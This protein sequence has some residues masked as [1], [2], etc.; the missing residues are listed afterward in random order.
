MSRTADVE[1]KADGRPQAYEHDH[2]GSDRSSE[3][4]E[5]VGAPSPSIS[6][7]PPRGQTPTPW[8]TRPLWWVVIVLLAIAATAII[9]VWW[10]YARQYES[11][12]D[13]FIAAHIVHIAPQVSGQVKAVLVKDNQDVQAGQVLVKID[14]STYQVALDQAQ[15]ALAQ[16]Q[17]KVAQAQAQQ[18]V[19]QANA[20]QAGAQVL[21]AQ[22][23]ARNAEQE[24]QRYQHLSK[25]AVSQQ[26]LDNAVAAA[27]SGAAKVEAAQK[28]AAAAQA[29]VKASVTAIETAQAA[30]KSA[31][32]NV[33][34]AKLML[35]YTQITAPQ[36]GLVT[37]KSV[38]EGNYV[39]V[40]QQ[41][42]AIVPH[43]VWVTA[44]FKETQLTHM[45]PGQP[46]EISVD[47]FPGIDYHGHV[48]SIQ[49]GSGAVF[50]LLP[51]ENATGNYVKVVQ[52]VPVKIV[53]DDRPQEPRLSP[54]MSVEPT[55][56]VR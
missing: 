48:D 14:P 6:E 22:A 10:L 8:Y 15:A 11:T 55:V 38:V 44:N 31:Q 20:L 33:E 47:A 27:T 37:K 46:V 51:P 54:G 50:S 17:G 21:V 35:S 7:P 43:H 18:A 19:D 1:D 3:A 42:M 12:D 53:F 32:A 24:L 36:S 45:K 5:D 41:L 34:Q 4:A 25:A 52:R 23:N 26:Q 56:K 40:G 28:Q 9:V 49:A 39:Q 30:V 2:A 13:A 29:Q 16:A